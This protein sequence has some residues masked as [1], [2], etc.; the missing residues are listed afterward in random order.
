MDTIAVMRLE[1]ELDLRL[2]EVLLEAWDSDC[3]TEGELAAFL[4]LAYASGYQDALRERTRGQLFRELGLPVPRRA[5][6]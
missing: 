6:I 4:R 5:R 2:R 1:L 3:S